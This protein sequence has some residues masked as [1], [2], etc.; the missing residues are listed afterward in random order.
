[1]REIKFRAFD[2]EFN[3]MYSGY[4]IECEDNLDAWLSYGELVTYRIDDGVY[5]QLKTLQ[6]TGLLDSK[7][8]EIYEGD[9]LKIN[10]LKFECSVLLPENLNVKYYGGMFQLYRGDENLMGLHLGYIEECEVIGNIYENP[11]LLK[12]STK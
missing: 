5:E 8:N 2:E 4:E 12:N 10:K 1:M 11:E 6:Y 9:I 7:G 3:V